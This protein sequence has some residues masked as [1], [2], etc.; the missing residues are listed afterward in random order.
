MAAAFSIFDV[1]GADGSF[2]PLIVFD[3][4]KSRC[5]SQEILRYTR[6]L[7]NSGCSFARMRAACYALGLLHDYCVRVCQGREGAPKPIDSLISQFFSTRRIGT[8]DREG[9]DN[10]GLHW[11]PV[12]RTTVARDRYYVAEYIDFCLQHGGNLIL[13]ETRPSS[14]E[15]SRTFGRIAR[16]RVTVHA[17][18]L[19][20]HIA[21]RRTQ[22][23]AFKIDISDRQTIRK[24]SVRAKHFPSP[25]IVAAMIDAT[26]SIIQ[27]MLL[28]E[29]FH[30]G[31]RLSELL[32]QW[33]CD[34]LPGRFRQNIFADDRASNVPLVLLAHPSQSR[35]LGD[36]RQAGP[37]RS[38]VLRTKYNLSPRHLIKPD[39]LWVGWKGMQF[40][41]ESLL[42]SQ[43]FWND[44]SRAKQFYD[45]FCRLRIEIYPAISEHILSSHP[46]LFINDCPE[47]PEFGQPMKFE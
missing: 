43:V 31:A 17:T 7:K 23:P 10:L 15:L 42:V 40:D 37:E 5:F 26:D 41:E 34:V 44:P 24:V 14:E 12:A 4:S 1:K 16:G 45:L 28:I 8:R 35:F 3:D 21:H 33:R 36:L 47:K 13:G 39:P 46:Y 20:H 25:E 32:H 19:L 27:K 18:D 22:R 29:A 11:S 30:G 6:Y 38:S 2:L 9:H